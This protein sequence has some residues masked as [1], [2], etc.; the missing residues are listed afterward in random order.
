MRNTILI[1]AL[2]VACVASAQIQYDHAFFEE[3]PCNKRHTGQLIPKNGG[4][5]ERGY[6]V[7]Y[8]RAEWAV[9]PAV[10]AIEGT[11][12]LHY[13][14][15]QALQSVWLDLSDTLF[16][17]AVVYHGS[18]TP[19]THTVGD[20]LRIDLP[21]ELPIGT[22]DS[23][24][25]SYHGVPRT[26]GF[27]SFGTGQQ[28]GGS[29]ALWTLSEPYGAKDWWPCKQDLNDKLDS[30]DLFVTTPSAY[31]VGS[32]GL[33]VAEVVNGSETT[34]HWRH[35]YPIAYYLIS[36]AV[37]DYIVLTRDIIIGTDTIPM[38]TY[39]WDDNPFMADLNAGDAASQMV[40]FSDLFGL[41]PF[42]NEKYGHAQ[43]GWGGGMEHQ[44]MT[45][46]GGWSFELSA[47]ELAH[48]WF[49]DK[50]TCGQWEDIW[51]NEGFA[52]YLQGMVYEFNVPQYW[53]PYLRGKIESV[54]SEPGGSVFCSDVTSVSRIFN[55]RLS[56]NKGAMVLHMLRWVC[57]NDA[58]F[59]GVRNYLDDPALAY[60][61]AVTDDLRMHLET[62]SGVDL[63][64]FM[65]DWYTGEGYPTYTIPWSQPS[66]GTVDLAIFQSTS[67]PSVDFF[68]MPVPIRFKNSTLDTIVV[69]DHQFS[70]QPF[71]VKLP[72][73][74]DSVLFDPDLWIVSG[75]NIVTRVPEL[76]SGAD[77]LVLFPNPATDV[78]IVRSMYANGP[79][80]ITL[81]DD[82]GRIVS[83]ERTGASGDITL[84]VRDLASGAYTLAVDDGTRVAR[85]RF[86]KQR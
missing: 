25:V 68:E 22:L 36:L 14:S 66:A 35:R 52:T 45:S 63:E 48:Q 10:R 86:I 78:L 51:L 21:E 31:R 24:T 3:A 47:H 7:K 61:S 1:I 41:Y 71:S 6:D 82:L 34:Y 60:G 27:G 18:T 74:V 8:L 19:F 55:G 69:F 2:C 80:T 42:A 54:V 64:G 83:S 4:P 73:T 13:V 9:D 59:Q 84:A 28:Q 58:W 65:A 43:F 17:D 72:F 67:H 56:Y 30:I 40:L 76:A 39:S 26:T 46:M 12:T 23:I 53:R 32:N 49:G 81:I 37:A 15:T 11:V 29:P 16:V 5:P 38:L 70:G 33:L 62:A 44:T 77:Q 57:G 20:T 85:S 79:R 50:V 75:E